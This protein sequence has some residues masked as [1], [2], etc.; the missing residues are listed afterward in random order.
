[1]WLE[2][3]VVP[4][5]SCTISGVAL[6]WTLVRPVALI[7]RK[8]PVQPVSAITDMGGKVVLDVLIVEAVEGPSDSVAA[9]GGVRSSSIIDSLCSKLI[10]FVAA[11]GLVVLGSPRPQVLAGVIAAG[12]CSGAFF[13]LVDWF[14][15]ILAANGVVAS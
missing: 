11:V 14:F 5:G 3:M 6:G 2:D 1:M 13:G 12:D 9:V 15:S 8:W 4:S 7:V 10:G